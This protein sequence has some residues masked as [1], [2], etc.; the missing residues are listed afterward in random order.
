MEFGSFMEFHRREGMSQAEAFQ[1]SFGLV[2]MA[3]DLG[4]DAIW[5]A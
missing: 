4:L 3:E 2:D 1:E 5:M